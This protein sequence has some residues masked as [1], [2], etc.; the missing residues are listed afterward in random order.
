[1]QSRRRSGKINWQVRI[2]LSDRSTQRDSERVGSLAAAR[3]NNNCAELRGR[4][5]PEQRN[6]KSGRLSLLIEWTLHQRVR[7]Q[8]D[9]RPPRLRLTGI[10]NPDLVTERTLVAP[11][12]SCKTRIHDCD[13]LLRVGV[14]DCEIAVGQIILSVHFVLAAAG[15]SHP[16]AIGHRGAFKL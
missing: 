11:I 13:R 15:K 7:N 2:D 14:I 12:L 5:R 6:K 1:M 8:T 16:K 10:E 4:R 3:T 9:N